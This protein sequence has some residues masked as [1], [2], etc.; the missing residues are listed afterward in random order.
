MF[1]LLPIAVPF[2]AVYAA[3]RILKG[4]NLSKYDE[5]I[6]VTFECDPE[7]GSLKEMNAYLYDNFE[8]PA[9][10]HKGGEP[11]A[12]KRE[13]FDK[14]GLVRDF[15]NVT[16]TPLSIPASWGD[17]QQKSPTQIS[18]FYIFTAAHL[19]LV[20]AYLTAP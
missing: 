11:I 17:I 10:G 6:P 12:S 18:E 5:D 9:E 8:L 20:P 4:E 3:T 15:P 19:L 14:G 16:F 1:Y 7:S 2:A 13:R